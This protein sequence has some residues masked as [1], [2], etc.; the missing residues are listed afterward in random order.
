MSHFGTDRVFDLARRR[1]YWPRMY[2]EIEYYITKQCNCLKNRRPNQPIRAPLEAVSTSSPMEIISIDILH[3]E[4]SVVGHE[5]ILV[6]VDHFTRYAQAYPCKNKSSSTAAS[7][8]FNDFFLRFGFPGQILHDQG[9]EFENDLSHELERLSGIK[10][11]RTTP[12]HAMGNGKA[13]R[14][15]QTLLSML[16]TLN[17]RDKLRWKDSINQVT[18]AYNCT[19]HDST[20]C[21]PYFLLFGRHPRLPIDLIF[22]TERIRSEKCL[23]LSTSKTGKRP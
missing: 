1:F 20:N 17:D 21:S 10:R 16:R 9:R 13:E 22:A 3:L 12:Y 6:V 19:K 7:K 15:N 4:R 18:L 23:M 11:L 14:F 5:Y 8:L 2:T